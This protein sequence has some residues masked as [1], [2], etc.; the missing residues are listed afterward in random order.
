MHLGN[1]S[2]PCASQKFEGGLL[3]LLHILG[4]AVATS[5][6]IDLKF[7]TYSELVGMS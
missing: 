4:I 3:S 1:F 7:S 2:S 5:K 6:G